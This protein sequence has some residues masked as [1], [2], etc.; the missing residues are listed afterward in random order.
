MRGYDA[1]KR[2]FGRKRRILVDAVGVV[3]F[4]HIHVANLHDQ[5]GAHHLVE[6]ADAGELLH[7]ELVW[8]DGAYAGTFARWLEAG[9]GWRVEVPK[10]RDRHMT[11]EGSW[12]A[13]RSSP[14]AG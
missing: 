6:R 9:Q 3:L 11:L 12:K 14:I 8:A 10:H 1:A 4:A 13:F 5:L 7:L 2:S